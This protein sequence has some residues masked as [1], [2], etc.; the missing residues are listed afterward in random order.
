MKRP[1]IWATLVIAVTITITA[2]SCSDKSETTQP[3]FKKLTAAVYASGTLLPEQEYKVVATA[4]G[5]LQE[6]Y[7]KEGDT[8]NK[9]QLL[10]Y[11][12]SEV[13]EAQEQG[14]DA[15]V[16][17]TM[18]TVREGAPMFK[19]LEGRIE[20][21]RIKLEQDELQYKRYQKLLEEDAISKSSYEKYYLQYQ[22]SLRDYQNLK[23]Q[24]EQQTLSGRLQLQQAQSQLQVNRAQQSAGRL[25]SFVDGIVY[26]IYKKQGDL[27][28]PN[29]PLALVGTGDMIAKLSV[30]EDDLDKV[31][32]GQDVLITMDAYDDKVFKAHIKKVYPVLNK[33]EQS[34]RVDAVFDDTLPVGIYGL[35]LEANIVLTDNKEVMVIPRTA[36]LKGDSVWVKKDGEEMK[37]PV[38][39]GIADDQWVEITSG[40]EKS[41]TIIL[42]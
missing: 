30:D 29:Q 38:K 16:Q 11:I 28:N 1:I 4:D 27:V 34:F 33:V 42:K 6:A 20:V 23:Q 25:K 12:S 5:Y 17:R 9:G 31:F 10:F 18:S 40:L 39:T 2:V 14:A 7:V 36:L 21:A 3:Q 15:V 19:E 32:E 22:G 26:D 37:V 24:Y 13:R 41:S 8:V 35:N